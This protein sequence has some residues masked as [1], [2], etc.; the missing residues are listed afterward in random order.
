MWRMYSEYLAPGATD[1]VNVDSRVA[2]IVRRSIE[3]QMDRYCLDEAE[4]RPPATLSSLPA[5]IT[6]PSLPALGP[7]APRAE[8]GPSLESVYRVSLTVDLCEGLGRKLAAFIAPSAFS[9]LTLLVGRQ[10]GHPACKN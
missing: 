8:R 9:A 7:W 4:V 1:P 6:V 5:R 2:D 3:H 10:E